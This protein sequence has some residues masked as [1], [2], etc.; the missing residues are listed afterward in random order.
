M[1]DVYVKDTL[2]T[3]EGNDRNEIII[4]RHGQF[5]FVI[6]LINIYGCQESWATSERI[7]EN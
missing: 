7:N 4:T 2:K 3:F 1:R 6:N 5:R